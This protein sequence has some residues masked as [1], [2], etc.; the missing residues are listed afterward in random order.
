VVLLFMRRCRYRAFVSPGWTVCR[1]VDVVSHLE[2]SSGPGNV[3]LT[4]SAKVP[5]AVLS[6]RASVRRVTALVLLPE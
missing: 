3:D 4:G 6:G 5:L 2:R 1:S